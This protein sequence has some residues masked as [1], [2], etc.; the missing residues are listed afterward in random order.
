MTPRL[1]LPIS[2]LLL[3]AACRTLDM[4]GDGEPSVPYREM[5]TVPERYVSAETPDEELDSLALWSGDNG[6]TWLIASG[7]SSDRLT[8]FD[9]DT[10]ATLRTFGKP[11]KGA[12]QFDRP[13][14]LAVFGDA[15]FVVERDSHRVQAFSLPAFAPLGAFGQDRLRSPY[16]IW[17]NE[18]APGELDAYVTDSYMDGARF[19]VV[20]PLAELD[21]RVRRYRIGFDGRG[22]IAAQDAGAFGDTGPATALKMVESIA[23]DPAHDLLLIADESTQRT[24]GG[25]STLRAYTLAGRYTG[26]SLPPESF[27]GEAE[28]VALWSCSPTGGYW[29]VVDQLAPLTVFHVFERATLAPRGSFR[30]RTTAHTDGVALLASATAAFP[31][32]AL[33]AVHDDKAVSAFDLSDVARTLRLSDCLP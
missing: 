16:G 13:N 20:P 19:D 24:A 8:V 1:L 12:G 30:G 29:V 32:G 27:A 14:G 17:L 31:G 25:R 26:R 5:P 15:L 6:A 18:T 7:K 22:R 21:Q 2:A 33:F 23:G 9:A 11:G 28:G 3:L 4:G 10:G